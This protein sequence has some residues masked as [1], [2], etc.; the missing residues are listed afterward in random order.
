MAGFILETFGTLNRMF[1]TGR[2]PQYFYVCVKYY[3][4]LYKLVSAVLGAFFKETFLK[5]GTV[6]EFVV[7]RGRGRDRRDR[8]LRGR[9]RSAVRAGLHTAAGA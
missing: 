3:N 8:G 6:L 4:K 5:G 1:S 9:Q 2:R 7:R